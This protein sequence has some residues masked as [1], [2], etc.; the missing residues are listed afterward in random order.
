[1]TSVAIAFCTFERP[2][3]LADALSDVLSQAPGD[4]E[5][6]VVDQSAA[7]QPH[8]EQMVRARA[9]ARLRYLY[10]PQPGLPAARNVAMR[11]TTAP[12]LIFLDDDVRVHAGCIAAHCAAFADP[13][14]SAVAGR[15]HERVLRPNSWFT[16]N[17][18]DRWGRVRY[19]LDGD[20]ARPVQAVKGAN[21]SFRRAMLEQIGWFDEGYTG[22]AYLEEA[23]VCER[24]RAVGGSIVFEP[25]AAV[26][27]L[28][29]PAGGVRQSDAQTTERWRFHNTGYFLT[30]NRP[31]AVARA[32]WVFTAVAARRAW[33]WRDRGAVAELMVAF[34]AGCRRAGG[35]P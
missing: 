31:E 7:A 5:V 15:I 12:I 35:N 8:N 3:P 27:H 25:A 21:M 22:T 26:T 1:V 10:R 11:E 32:R 14:V 23:D 20:T 9:D 6:I 2:Q 24:I 28:S 19:Q 16:R 33:E 29:A 4:A 34:D 18:V 13:R 17:E 30:K